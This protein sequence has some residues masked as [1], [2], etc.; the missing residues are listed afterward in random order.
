[1]RA[2]LLLSL[3]VVAAPASGQTAGGLPLVGRW[4]AVEVRGDAAATADLADGRLEK[5]LVVHPGG[6]AMLRGTD[7]AQ[8][9]G[10]PQQFT[11]RVD[12]S[13]LRLDGLP[14]VAR[15][16]AEGRRLVMADPR[17]VETVYLRWPPDETDRPYRRMR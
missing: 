11:G 17:G 5:V 1:M 2:A 16:R 9:A 13:A 15:L 3:L 12:G 10:R 6:R 8:D 7:H 4:L 14:G